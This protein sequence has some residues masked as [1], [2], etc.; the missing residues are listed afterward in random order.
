MRKALYI[1]LLLFT[2]LN[3]I[4]Q[5]PNKIRF[6][7]VIENRKSDT[8]IIRGE[9]SFNQIILINSLQ[10]FE[11]LIDAPKGFY[12]FF[13]GHSA[14]TMY[15]KPEAEIELTYDA[16][17]FETSVAYKGK[18][19]EE[20]NFLAQY[21]IRE[22]IFTDMAFAKEPNEFNTLFELKR[23]ED[24][25]SISKGNFDPEFKKI[26]LSSFDNNDRYVAQAY[27]NITR[28]KKSQGKP[29]PE[30][31]YENHKGGQTKLSDLK[32]KYVYIDI[33]ATWCAPCRQEIPFLQKIEKKYENKNITFVSISIDQKKDYEKWKSFVTDKNLG[34]IQLL[35]D[36]DWNSEFI[37]KYEIRGIPRFI[38]I[39][40]NG[41]IVSSDI[42]R[43]SDPKLQEKLDLLLQ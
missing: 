1:S 2:T 18:G 12:Q 8:L 14:S 41:N 4:A 13:D 28:A 42:Q 22:E 38:L 11:A 33:W 27:E 20:S 31:N 29:S 9:N 34:G 32:G 6:K 37:L 26:I 23:K 43:P 24:R 16:N 19:S 36:N 39:D 30:F 40:P 35:A 3:L 21:S 17:K 25:E 10:Q 5:A 15:L 7:A